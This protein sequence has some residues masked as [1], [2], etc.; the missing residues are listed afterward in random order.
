[1]KLKRYWKEGRKKRRG[2]SKDDVSF[3][4]ALLYLLLFIELKQ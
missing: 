1:M 4:P 2:A 3:D